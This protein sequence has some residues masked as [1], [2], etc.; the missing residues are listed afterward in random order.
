MLALSMLPV[1]I[2][3]SRGPDAVAGVLSQDLAFLFFRDVFAFG[4]CLVLREIYRRSALERLSLLVRGGVVVGLSLLFAALDVYVSEI[5]F[6]MVQRSS[7]ALSAPV[8]VAAAFWLHVMI[9][10]SWSCLYFLLKAFFKA[11]AREREMAQ[12]RARQRES[13]LLMLRAHLEPHFIFNALNAITILS[14]GNHG[15]APVVKGLSDYLR[16]C[17]A[18]RDRLFV[19]LGDELDA[20]CQYLEVERARF[21][22]GL[23][24]KVDVDD[25]LSRHIPVPGVFLMPLVENALKHRSPGGK[26]LYL[27]IQVEHRRAE[28]DDAVLEELKLHP[29]YER[30]HASPGSPA[31]HAALEDVGNSR[32][33]GEGAQGELLIRVTS[34]S[35]W[36]GDAPVAEAHAATGVGLSNLKRRL[37]LLYPGAERT[38]FSLAPAGGY[39]VAEIK[40]A[41]PLQAFQDLVLRGKGESRGNPD[42]RPQGREL[43][44]WLPGGRISA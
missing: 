19:P 14:H 2:L 30:T 17:L 16:F 15:V 9:F 39:V 29:P 32:G 25:P 22:E 18:N 38:A 28:G 34:N 44:D 1:R 27:W 5:V 40:I 8:F 12:L 6:G 35:E 3:V 23:V 42:E 20:I 11:K 41:Q 36:R 26:P 4:A 10:F 33:K 31:I 21:G 24:I 7:T 37:E 43:P 13:E